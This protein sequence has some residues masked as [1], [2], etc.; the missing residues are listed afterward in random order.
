MHFFIFPYICPYFSLISRYLY[1]FCNDF[2]LTCL[3]FPISLIIIK[4]QYNI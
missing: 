3:W 2:V 1:I 4:L